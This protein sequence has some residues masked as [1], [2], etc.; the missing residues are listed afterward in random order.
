METI[1]WLP[2]VGDY[3]AAAVLS[4]AFNQ[5]HAVV[6][7]NVERLFCRLFDIRLP[8]N[9]PGLK[10][11]YRT[12]AAQL[13]SP[14]SPGN[15]NQALMEMG[16]KLCTP[17]RPECGSCPVSTVCLASARNSQQLAP[18]AKIRQAFTDVQLTVQIPLRRNRIGLVMRADDSPFLKGSR[19][20]L[21]VRE[22]T[23][24]QEEPAHFRHTI[25][26]HRI[27]GRVCTTAVP[28]NRS[29]IWVKQDEV[30]DHLT[31][32][33]DAKAWQAA[34]RAGLQDPG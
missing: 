21:L 9:L 24:Q 25:T 16:Q 3:I 13:V 10:K 6:D 12:I 18:A 1:M 29:V 4:I 22:T 19:G 5:P 2:G 28:A 15:F 20:F 17:R 34:L 32:S 27:H 26:R 11:P 23:L 14:R 8:P 7:G 33:L 31:T 30:A